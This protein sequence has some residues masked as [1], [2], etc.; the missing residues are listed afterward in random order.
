MVSDVCKTIPLYP[1]ATTVSLT[2]NPVLVKGKVLKTKLLVENLEAKM[3]IQT[4][5]KFIAQ[6]GT[7]IVLM[8]VG[9][10]PSEKSN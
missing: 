5:R 6:L 4:H 10:L 9:S 2:C 1:E 8:L 7:V 3:K